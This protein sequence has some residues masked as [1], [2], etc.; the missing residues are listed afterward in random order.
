MIAIKP[1]L[2]FFTNKTYLKIYIQNLNFLLLSFLQLIN[3]QIIGFDKNIV[4]SMEND[5]YCRDTEGIYLSLVEPRDGRLV[6]SLH[7]VT[8]VAVKSIW[9]TAAKL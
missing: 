6:M 9:F 3:I 2:H 5:K 1:I 8:I 4:F 7:T